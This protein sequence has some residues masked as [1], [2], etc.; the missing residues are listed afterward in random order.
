MDGKI[1]I[2]TK[3][4]VL[5]CISNLLMAISF[6]FILSM[7]PVYIESVLKQ[8]KTEVGIV[9]SVYTIASLLI[10]PVAGT[11]LDHWGRKHI[12]LI[13]FAF[14][15]SVYFG[16][17]FAAT[18]FLL[19]IVRFI[20]GFAWGV[21]SVSTSTIV[22]DIIPKEKRGEGIGIFGVTMTIGMAIGPYIGLKIYENT[23]YNVFFMAAA[24]ISLMGFVLALFIKYPHF[25]SKEKESKFKLKELF[26]KKTIPVSLIMFLLMFN[27]GGIITYIIIYAKEIG[28]ERP[29]LFFVFYSVSVLISRITAGKMFDKGGHKAIIIIGIILSVIG[30]PILAL[31]KNDFGFFFSSIMLGLGNGIIMPTLQAMANNLVTQNERGSANSTFSTFL[32]LGIAAGALIIGGISDSITISGSYIFCSFISLIALIFFLSFVN[33]YYE[34]NKLNI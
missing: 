8:S 3:D 33:K 31:A 30:F 4:F 24:L 21:V 2:W 32:D 26:N 23:D 1:T 14:F 28:V 12:Y 19:L 13:F 25:Q 34:K 11:A 17:I 10:R 6:Y 20:H 16:Y 27:Y 18:I 5:L 9:M 15:S 22:V 29:G 7:L